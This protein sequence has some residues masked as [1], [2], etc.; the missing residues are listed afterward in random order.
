MVFRFPLPASRFPLPASR[1]YFAPNI[2][3]A[4]IFCI[5]SIS[6]V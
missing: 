1:P 3:D 6:V 4:S 5:R 2:A